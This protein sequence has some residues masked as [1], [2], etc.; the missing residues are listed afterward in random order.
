M[1]EVENT[2]L[3]KF[4]GWCFYVVLTTDILLWY[5][6]MIAAQ[7]TD[8]DGTPYFDNLYLDFVVYLDGTIIIDNMDELKAALYQH[9]IIEKQFYLALETGARLK[10]GLLRDISSFASFTRKCHEM[11]VLGR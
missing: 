8:T 3:T 9:D 1:K 2:T 11:A 5:I 7:G 6:D 4:Q 10:N